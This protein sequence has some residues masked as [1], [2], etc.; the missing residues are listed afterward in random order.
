MVFG[1]RLAFKN[2]NSMDL[3]CLFDLWNAI[4]INQLNK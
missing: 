2:L 1:L 4:G 3:L